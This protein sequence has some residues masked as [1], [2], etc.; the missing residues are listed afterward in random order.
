[1]ITDLQTLPVSPG[2]SRFFVF[3]Q[4]PNEDVKTPGF[5]EETLID[6]NCEIKL[7]KVCFIQQNL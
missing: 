2:D 4:S 1:M 7:L 5:S 6:I 3:S